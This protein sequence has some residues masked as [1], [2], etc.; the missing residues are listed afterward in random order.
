[1]LNSNRMA[2]LQAI[3]YKQDL[4]AGKD[5][6]YAHPSWGRRYNYAANYNFNEELVCKIAEDVGCKNEKLIQ[7]IVSHYETINLS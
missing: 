5:G 7:Q 3:R 2:L 6:D 4:V 1:M